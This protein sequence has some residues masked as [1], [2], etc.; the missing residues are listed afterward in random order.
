[1]HELYAP[2]QQWQLHVRDIRDYGGEVKAAAEVRMAQGQ[3]PQAVSTTTK[4][5]AAAA[6]GKPD[7]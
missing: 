7:E 2:Q 1:M 6:S 3:P 5:M 4:A